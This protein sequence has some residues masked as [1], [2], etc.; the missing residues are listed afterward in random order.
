M[1]LALAA[2][3]AILVTLLLKT[4][5]VMALRGDSLPAL[6]RKWLEYVPVA[7]MAALVGPDV[8]MQDG[9]LDISFSN[10]FLL[11]SLPTLLVA[12][13]S[14]NYFVTIAAGIGLVIL[15]RYYGIG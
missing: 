4:G 6:L 2:A 14:R 10:L 15:A 8:F 1:T 7:V 11:V 3:L 13:F 9:R 12:V 5:P